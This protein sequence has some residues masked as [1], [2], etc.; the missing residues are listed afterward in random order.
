MLENTKELIVNEIAYS[1]HI[2]FAQ[3]ETLVEE[4]CFSDDEEFPPT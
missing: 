3:A 4:Y 1:K 2:R